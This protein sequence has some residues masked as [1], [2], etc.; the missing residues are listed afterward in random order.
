MSV[1]FFLT[2]Y[3]F[4]WLDKWVFRR[5]SYSDIA[6]IIQKKFKNIGDKLQGAVEL[7]M[8]ENENLYSEELRQ[9]ALLQT[10][11]ETENLDFLIA[12]DQKK[13]VKFIIL[14]LFLMIIIGLSA[15]FATQALL[16][17]FKRLIIPFSNLQR[18]T[19]V[20][21]EQVPEKLIVPMEENFSLTVSLSKNTFLKPQKG[22]AEFQGNRIFSKNLSNIYSFDFPGTS[23]Q[24]IISLRIG[25]WQKK[26]AVIPVYRPSPI[27]IYTKVIY[28]EYIGKSEQTLLSGSK[29]RILENSKLIVSGKYSRP[30][31]SIKVELDRTSLQSNINESIFSTSEFLTPQKVS[32]ITLCAKDN[33]GL[34]QKPQTILKIESFQDSLPQVELSGIPNSSAILKEDILDLHLS[35]NDDFGLKYTALEISILKKNNNDDWNT[36]RKFRKTFPFNHSTQTQT[37]KQNIL[38]SPISESISPGE[39]LIMKMIARDFKP[40]SPESSSD[41]KYIYILTQEEHLKI[42]SEK[43]EELLDKIQNL[44]YSENEN[45]QNNIKVSES[46]SKKLENLNEEILEIFQNEATNKEYALQIANEMANALKEALKNQLF[47]DKTASQWTEILSELYELQKND[48]SESCNTLKSA[49]EKPQRKDKLNDAQKIQSEIVKKL[50]DLISKSENSIS[51]A[52]TANFAARLRKEAENEKKLQSQL[53]DTIKVSAGIN[54]KNASPEIIDLIKKHSS[55]HSDISNSV[56]DIKYDLKAIY[57]RRPLQIYQTVLL[58]MEKENIEKLLSQNQDLIA[59]NKLYEANEKSK[60]I[61][62]KL[63]EWAEFIEESSK[64]KTRVESNQNL[65]VPTEVIAAL[66]RAIIKETQLRKKTKELN[67]TKEKQNYEENCLNLSNEQNFIKGIIHDCKNKLTQQIPQIISTLN[68]IAEPMTDAANLLASKKTDSETVGAETE[69]I[70]LISEL[71]SKISEENASTAAV[72]KAVTGTSPGFGIT[73]DSNTKNIN[74]LGEQFSPEQLEKKNEKVSKY[75]NFKIPERYKIF[76]ESYLKKLRNNQ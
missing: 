6:V 22:V 46:D 71:L 35:A 68:K 11:K 76:Y 70:E 5:R 69:A 28:P 20:I 31:N 33:Y 51:E 21:P 57:R 18:F 10:A 54:I 60:Y 59:E 75:T 74:V 45:L 16:N 26:I 39:L 3:I 47:S 12:I 61:E 73:S 17:S 49:L 67:I 34:E 43:L 65:K 37:F 8:Q 66:M 38:F 23:S 72:T 58:D 64:N 42:L 1:L 41:E 62:T 13:T 15:E 32:E 19:F 36:E 2:K 7:S 24:S 25:D 55:T 53:K 27:E 4:N 29:I 14:S 50:D 40:G 63:T 44:K 9:A 48:F 52:M 30:L 56:M